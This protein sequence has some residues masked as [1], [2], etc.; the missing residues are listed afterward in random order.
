MS[1]AVRRGLLVLVG[2]MLLQSAWIL[3]VP[4][5]RG[6]DE[7]DHAFRAAGVATGQWHLSEQA[8]NGRGAAR[9]GS[10][11]PGPCRL[12]AVLIAAVH[13]AR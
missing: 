10:R 9:P 1:L 3:A 5:F 11:G 8:S 12:R 7:F 6:S 2:V 4:P 13:R